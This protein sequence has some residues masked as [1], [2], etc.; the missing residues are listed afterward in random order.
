[1]HKYMIHILIQND[2]FIYIVYRDTHNSTNQSVTWKRPLYEVPCKLLSIKG[3]YIKEST[4]ISPSKREPSFPRE[5]FQG[6]G[7]ETEKDCVRE[8]QSEKNRDR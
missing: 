2:I 1:M 3:V 6:R 7:D 8:I 5:V 4:L